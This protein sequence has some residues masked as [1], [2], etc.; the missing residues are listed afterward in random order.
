MVNK[1]EVISIEE[2][3]NQLGSQKDRSINKQNFAIKAEYFGYEVEPEFKFIENRRFRADWKVSKGKKCVL[4]EYEGINASKAR[5]TSFTGYTKDCEKY[6]L[7]Q[8]NGYAVLRYTMI[9]FCNVFE[10]L[11]AFFNQ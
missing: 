9:N 6:N 3:R 2:Y 4:V 11:N 5:H 7:A 8:I 1:T 10:D